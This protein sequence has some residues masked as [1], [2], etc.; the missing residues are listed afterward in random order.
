MQKSLMA[1]GAEL[2]DQGRVRGAWRQYGQRMIG[3]IHP[4]HRPFAA[5]ASRGQ[6]DLVE[7]APVDFLGLDGKY[8]RRHVDDTGC[9]N[10]PAH[11]PCM[12][13]EQNHPRPDGVDPRLL[14][15]DQCGWATVVTRFATAG[16]GIGRNTFERHRA[17]RAGPLQFVANTVDLVQV[18]AAAA[19]VQFSVKAEVAVIDE[20]QVQRHRECLVRCAC[21]TAVPTFAMRCRP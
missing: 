6:R 20:I 11:R 17:I 14:L 1:T 10:R 8:Q 9:A 21:Q 12:V 13:I 3:R 4:L 18:C 15:G 19:Y 7:Y 16:L 5:P 2:D